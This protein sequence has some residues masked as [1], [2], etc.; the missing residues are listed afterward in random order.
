MLSLYILGLI[1]LA[2]VVVS[3]TYY[4]IE[5]RDATDDRITMIIKPFTEKRGSKAL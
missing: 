2:I 3:V 4:R 1:N 5:E